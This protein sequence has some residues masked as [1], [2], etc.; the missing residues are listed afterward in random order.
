[1]VEQPAARAQQREQV[2]RVSCQHRLTHMLGHADAG[3]RVKGPVVHVAVV[4]DPDL[5]LIA[6]TLFDR[7]APG[8]GGLLSRESNADSLDAIIAGSVADKGSPPTTD[9]DNAHAR[10]KSELARHQV[11]L[12]QLGLVQAELGI[13][14]LFQRRKSGQQ[15]P[16]DQYVAGHVGSCEAQLIGGPEQSTQGMRT[17]NGQLYWGARWAS[18]TAVPT[19]QAHGRTRAQTGLNQRCHD[20]CH[21]HQSLC[22]LRIDDHLG[23]R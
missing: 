7:P 22:R 6:D 2:L 19:G 20:I 18:L 14:N 12:G 11:I 4:L 13:G 23:R 10:L 1:M 16:P 3:N 15:V 8:I 17:G 5:H 9:V 21:A